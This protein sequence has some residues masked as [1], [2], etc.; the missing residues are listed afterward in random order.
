MKVIQEKV[1][2]FFYLCFQVKNGAQINTKRKSPV[3]E[4]VVQPYQENIKFDDDSVTKKLLFN[5]VV[6][7]H[8]SLGSS[9]NNC[10][11]VVVQL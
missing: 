2:F 4:V 7:I 6:F 5:N 10:K 8:L 11:A 9:P 1:L 3:L